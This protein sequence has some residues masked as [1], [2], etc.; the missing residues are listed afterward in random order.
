MKKDLIIL[1][2]TT[3]SQL[4]VLKTSHDTYFLVLSNN[5]IYIRYKTTWYVSDEKW[6]YADGEMMVLDTH[7]NLLHAR[8]TTPGRWQS[9]FRPIPEVQV[10]LLRTFS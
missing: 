7:E 1:R 9:I 4:S 6:E 10:E 8:T 5:H 2:Y 3:F